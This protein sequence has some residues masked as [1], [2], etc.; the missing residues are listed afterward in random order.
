MLNKCQNLW[1]GGCLGCVCVC[2]GGGNSDPFT[3]LTALPLCFFML[4][5]QTHTTENSPH[6][7]HSFSDTMNLVIHTIFLNFIYQLGGGGVNSDPFTLLTALPLCFFMLKHQ[8]HTTENSPH[9]KH[10]FSDTMNLVIHTIFLNFIYQFSQFNLEKFASFIFVLKIFVYNFIVG[11]SGCFPGCAQMNFCIIVGFSGCVQIKFCI[12]V[13]FSGCVQM[14]F[15]ISVGFSGCAAMKL[16]IIS[17]L[18]F[19]AVLR[20]SSV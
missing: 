14:N 4:K 8:I 13:G 5:H 2:V 20:W 15:C 10:S 17:L 6:V 1:V 18:V 9:V 16:C 7:K 11:F 19:Q 3:L 12:V